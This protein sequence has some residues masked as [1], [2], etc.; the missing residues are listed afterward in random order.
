[1][2]PVTVGDELRAVADRDGQVVVAHASGFIQGI[3]H[4]R[5]LDAVD[6]RGASVVMVH[7]VGQFVVEGQPL[8]R[9]LPASAAAPLAGE[10]HHAVE[11]GPWRTQR[12]DP[13]YAIYQVV[14]IAIRA[15]SPAVND[16]FTGMVCVDWLGAALVRQDRRHPTPLLSLRVQTAAK[17]VYRGLELLTLALPLFPQQFDLAFKT[18]VQAVRFLGSGLFSLPV[19]L[20]VRRE[21]S[22]QLGCRYPIAALGL[23]VYRQ[24]TC[25]YSV[26][27][28]RLAL[29]GDRKSVV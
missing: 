24:T 21:S 27:D 20:N 28:G 1:M 12:Q 19:R 7:R 25:F 2:Q 13:E 26:R 9:V 3:D 5:I 16:T 8:A 17:V 15:L 6:A 10:L 4:L 11:I 14:E 22:K 23:L 29:S 18:P